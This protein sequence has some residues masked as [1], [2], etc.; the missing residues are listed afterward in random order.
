MTNTVRVFVSCV[1]MV[2]VVFCQA[3]AKTDSRLLQVHL[4]REVTI[5]SDAAKLGQVGIIRGEESLVAKAGEIA[6]CRISV[7]GQKIIIDK[8]LVLSRLACNGIAASKVTLTG[9]EKT[10]VKRQQQIIKSEEF[11]EPAKSFIEKHPPAVS[12]C[13]F[14]LV[15]MP[16][17][18]II[19]G[20]SEDV[21]LVP[22]LSTRSVRNHAKVLVS[23]FADGRQIGTREVTFRL[24]YNHR[25]AITLVDIPS[26]SAISPA[27]VKV[28]NALSNH[29]EPVN[30]TAPYGLV[31][32]RRLPAN[33]VIRSNMAGP[34]KPAVLIKRNEN[35]V[36]KID[37]QE[38]YITAMGKAMQDGRAGEYIKVRVQISDIPRTIIAKVNEDGTLEPVF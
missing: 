19:R 18:L 2:T 31:A 7:P 25:K 6:L 8:T 14:E 15:R 1:F 29:P 37:K 35:V 32:K 30:W 17:N 33:T 26:G 16:E 21:K 3:S 5:D 23:A 27:N 10:S 12:I 13:Q 34:A 20:M 36:I 9:A 24:K 28:V 11:V 22:S 4:P 38:F